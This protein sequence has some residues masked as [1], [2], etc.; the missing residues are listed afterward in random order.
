MPP[1]SWEALRNGLLKTN[2]CSLLRTKTTIIFSDLDGTI[3][4]RLTYDYHESLPSIKWLINNRIPLIFCSAK[5]RCEMEEINA[6]IGIDEPFIVENGSAIILPKRHDSDHFGNHPLGVVEIGARVDNFKKLLQTALDSE[7]ISYT[8]FDEMTP[9]EISSDCGLPVA[10]AKLAKKREYTVTLKVDKRKEERVKAVIQKHGLNCSS[11]GRYLTVG[12]G[13][14]KGAAVSQVNNMYLQTCE[15]VSYAFGDGENDLS[16][17]SEVDYPI[18]VQKSP[19]VWTETGSNKICRI[20]FTGPSGFV[21]GIE[22][23][24]KP[25]LGSLNS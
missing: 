4:D 22:D 12:Q 17:F 11:G 9:E 3:L 7:G 16:M 6:A 13:G 18:L 8:T 1:D 21:K 14:S 10:Q 20:P 24:I 25:A 5:T 15:I 2:V 19:G 23:I